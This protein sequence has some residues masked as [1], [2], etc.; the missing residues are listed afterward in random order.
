[1]V[2][3][4]HFAVSHFLGCVVF[5]WRTTVATV[6][7]TA[8]PLVELS[9][10]KSITQQCLADRPQPA[11]SSLGLSLP[12]ALGGTAGPLHAGFT[13]PATVRLQGLA[14]LL[15]AYS[16]Q[17][18]AGFVS[19]RQRSWDS[20]FGA[21][22]SR[23]VSGSF[24]TR[25]NPPTVFPIGIPAPKYGPARWAAVPGLLPFRESLAAN[26][27]CSHADCWM[28]PWVSPL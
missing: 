27:C 18:R 16:P 26:A 7:R 10:P 2:G 28:L 1:L 21:F 3:R 20:P 11:S 8:S 22:S 14:T 24:P 6:K 23:K 4:P 25:K 13:M 12:S 5:P 17:F 15:T 9:L 19:H